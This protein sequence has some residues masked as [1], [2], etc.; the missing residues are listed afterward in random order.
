LWCRITNRFCFH[1]SLSSLRLFFCKQTQPCQDAT[2]TASL[3]QI[4]D[5]QAPKKKKN[6]KN[7]LTEAKNHLARAENHLAQAK[8]ARDQAKKERDQ[9]KK[10]RDG[11]FQDWRNEQDPTAKNILRGLLAETRQAVKKA[12]AR[13]DRA[14]ARLDRADARL[15]RADD[16]VHKA[17]GVVSKLLASNGNSNGTLLRNM[18]F[19]L[20]PSLLWLLFV[21]F[22]FF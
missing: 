5:P 2:A 7:N 21:P 1:L 15:D 20:F 17:N 16:S 12:E 22:L 18:S 14:D 11:A 10:E 19:V 4:K 13:L 6:K 8:M 3:G 9:A